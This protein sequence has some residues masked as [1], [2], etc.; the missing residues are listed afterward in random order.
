MRRV[1][2]KIGEPAPQVLTLRG[3]TYR[4]AL[5]FLLRVL[6]MSLGADPP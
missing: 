1:V 5:K 2:A 6:N 4:P 3:K